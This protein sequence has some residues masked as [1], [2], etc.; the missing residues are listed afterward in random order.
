MGGGTATLVPGSLV[1]YTN[2][3]DYGVVTALYYFVNPPSGNRTVTALF[4]TVPTEGKVGCVDLS[5]ADQ[6]TPIGAVQT[7]DIAGPTGASYVLS[8]SITSTY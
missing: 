4:N 3:T 5:N 6:T 7:Q 2:G 8:T 1:I